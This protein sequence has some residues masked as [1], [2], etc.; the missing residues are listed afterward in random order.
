MSGPTCW[1]DQLLR[2]WGYLVIIFLM[3]SYVHFLFSP[4]EILFSSNVSALLSLLL[5]IFAFPAQK[6]NITIRVTGPSFPS[7]DNKRIPCLSSVAHTFFPSWCHLE[8]LS[9]PPLLW[10]QPAPLGAAVPCPVMTLPLSFLD[11]NCVRA[12]VCADILLSTG[13]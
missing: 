13:P 1:E 4:V 10:L 9:L 12:H 3:V 11:L 8:D 2:L 5:R 7:T 6:A